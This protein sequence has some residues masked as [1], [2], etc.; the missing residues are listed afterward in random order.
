MSYLEFCTEIGS[1]YLLRLD[2]S[3]RL[4]T[5]ITLGCS[6]TALC[7]FAQ[8][9]PDLDIWSCSGVRGTQHSLD[10]PL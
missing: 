10:N 7:G 1:L 2:V 3:V 6:P 8:I 4:R 9:V 5:L